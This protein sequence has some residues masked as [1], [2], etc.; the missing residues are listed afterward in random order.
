MEAEKKKHYF[1]LKNHEELVLDEYFR[2]KIG[3]GNL[4]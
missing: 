2:G 4:R 1:Q 3:V